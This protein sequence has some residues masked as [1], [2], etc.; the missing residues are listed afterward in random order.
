[1]SFYN[2][3]ITSKLAE[4]KEFYTEVLGFSIKFDSDWF[5]L[6]EKDGRELAFMLPNLASQNKIFHG[7]LEGKGTWITME[8]D[9]F[10]AEYERLKKAGIEII[11]EIT[12]EEWGET[13]FAIADPIG[14]GIDFVKVQT[15]E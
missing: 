7:E 14:I 2:G 5:I 15:N 13:H 4:T 8:T 12:K 11:V 6:L 9:N 1:M 3:I 10:E